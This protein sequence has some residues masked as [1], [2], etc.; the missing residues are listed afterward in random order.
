MVALNRFKVLIVTAIALATIK[1][2]APSHKKRQ[3]SKTITTTIMAAT[4]TVPKIV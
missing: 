1:A 4:N 2:P 3:L